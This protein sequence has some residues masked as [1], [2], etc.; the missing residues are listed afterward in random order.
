MFA[1][2][3]VKTREEWLAGS[4]LCSHGNIRRGRAFGRRKK[5]REREREREE[6]NGK[7]E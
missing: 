2:Y 4:P 7:Q 5:S 6:K 3:K 1:V